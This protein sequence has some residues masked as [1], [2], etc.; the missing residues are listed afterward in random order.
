MRPRA[1]SFARPVARDNQDNSRNLPVGVPPQD[2]PTVV[3]LGPSSQLDLSWMPEDQR[4]A[5]LT[6]YAKGALD[7]ARKANEL[8]VEVSTLRSTLGTLADNTRQV[9]QDGNSITVTHVQNSSFGRTEVIMGN[10]ETAGKGRLSKSQT[11]ERDWTPIYV[12]AGIVALV[13]IAF[14]A[15]HR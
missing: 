6:D 3:P 9:A 1:D 4:R 13:L 2:V 5:L 12:I 10:T 8:G 14:A 11:G 15:F 7:I